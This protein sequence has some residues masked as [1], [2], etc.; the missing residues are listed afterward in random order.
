M[1]LRDMRENP[2]ACYVKYVKT[3]SRDWY[4]LKT[5][6]HAGVSSDRLGKSENPVTGQLGKPENPVTTKPGHSVT[7]FSDLPNR[8]TGFC[9]KIV[10]YKLIN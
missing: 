1:Y 2:V 10:N 7:G 3:Q 4:C 8:G 9:S 6:S 5:Q